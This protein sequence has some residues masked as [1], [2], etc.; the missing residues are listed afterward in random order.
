MTLKELVGR[1]RE[2]AGDYG[3]AIALSELGLPKDELERELSAYDE[4]YHISRFLQLTRVPDSGEAGS[5]AVHT[6]NG[7]EYTHVAIL[8]EIET[9][10]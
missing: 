8:A 10:L 3:R 1:Y 5:A 4:D 7:F 6:I 2:S 9:I